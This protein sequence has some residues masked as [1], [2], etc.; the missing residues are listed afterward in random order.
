LSNTEYSRL[1]VPPNFLNK[2]FIEFELDTVL[3]AANN[4]TVYTAAQLNDLIIKVVIAEPDQTTT[5]DETLAPEYNKT[6]YQIQR[7]YNKQPLRR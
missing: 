3:T 5:Q 2:G 1:P 7:V 4:G 6:D